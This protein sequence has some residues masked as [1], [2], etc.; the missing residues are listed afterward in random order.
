MSKESHTP[1]QIDMFTGEQVDTRS[2]TQKRR[3]REQAKPQQAEMFAASE[4]AQF[5]VNPHPLIDLSPHTK[6]TL[7][8]EDPRTEEEVE[9]DR[10]RAAEE[11]TYKMFD[12]ECKALLVRSVLALVVYEPPE[13]ALVPYS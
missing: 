10:Q 7:S 11:N 4:L 9:R 5:G 6:L 13:R 3:D 8:R 1:L 12:T 2:P